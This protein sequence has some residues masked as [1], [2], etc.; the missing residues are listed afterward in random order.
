MLDHG[1]FSVSSPHIDMRINALPNATFTWFLL[2][3]RP[4]VWACL[5]N[6]FPSP[7]DNLHIHDSGMMKTVIRIKD[8]SLANVQY[9]AGDVIAGVWQYMGQPGGSFREIAFDVLLRDAEGWDYIAYGR[10]SV[11]WKYEPIN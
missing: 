3:K 10:L 2:G 9:F 11:G 4:I 5:R 7:N 6:P 8:K 1:Q